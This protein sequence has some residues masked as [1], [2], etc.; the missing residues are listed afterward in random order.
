ACL[1][2]CVLAD[3]TRLVKLQNPWHQGRWTGKWS[4]LDRDSWTPA[5]QE[6]LKFDLDSQEQFDNGVFYME[7]HDV[8][9]HFHS[10]HIA[11]NAEMLGNGVIHSFH[12]RINPILPVQ[13]PRTPSPPLSRKVTGPM[14]PSSSPSSSSPSSS[15]SSSSLSSSSSCS[16]S[17]STS[18]P[19]LLLSSSPLSSP[20]SSSSGSTPPSPGSQ[21]HVLQFPSTSPPNQRLASERSSTPPIPAAAPPKPRMSKRFRVDERSYRNMPQY[22]IVAEVPVHTTIYV[23]VE[24]HVFCPSQRRKEHDNEAHALYWHEGEGRVFLPPI[25]QQVSAY[26]NDVYL[27]HAREVYPGRT[28]FTLVVSHYDLQNE[29]NFSIHICSTSPAAVWTIS[30]PPALVSLEIEGQWA[31]LSAGGPFEERTYIDNPSW[32]VSVEQPTMLTIR[33]ECDMDYFVNLL[34]VENP[35]R[36]PINLTRLLSYSTTSSGPYRRHCCVLRK[37]IDRHNAHYTLIPS[38]FQQGQQGSFRLCFDSSLSPTIFAPTLSPFRTFRHRTTITGSWSLANDGGAEHIFANPSYDLHPKEL[39]PLFARLQI[40]RLDC[41]PLSHRIPTQ[42]LPSINISIFSASGILI[43][44]SGNYMS[45]TYGC[46]LATQLEPR[47]PP[48]FLVVSTFSPRGH[49]TFELLLFTNSQ[50]SVSIKRRYQ[51]PTAPRR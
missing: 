8:C 45:S 37:Q 1:D 21:Q 20:L 51:S 24:R 2:I 7:F 30:E 6:E 18:A 15:S 25:E 29:M 5:L 40:T 11:W 13:P 42:L 26:T 33:L 10:A 23:L 39:T 16:M 47:A 50:L 34:L 27:L 31:K 32:A 41:Y 35:D 49:G 28:A 44:S 38:T 9:R 48:H 12:S 43:A 46:A 14:I 17:P 3:G 19:S 4:V 22:Q 36:M